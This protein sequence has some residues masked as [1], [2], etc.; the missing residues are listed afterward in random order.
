MPR[1]E[2]CPVCGNDEFIGHQYGWCFT[3]DTIDHVDGP[4]EFECT[5][6]GTRIGRWTGDILKDGETEPPYGNVEERARR[7]R[8]LQHTG[9]L[10]SETSEQPLEG[11]GSC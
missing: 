11:G 5:K 10:P 6:C 7:I 9:E 4:S 1:P 8:Y 2:T 3:A